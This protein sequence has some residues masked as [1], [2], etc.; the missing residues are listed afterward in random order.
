MSTD[1]ILTARLHRQE[2]QDRRHSEPTPACGRCGA[3]GEFHEPWHLCEACVDETYGK[4]DPAMFVRWLLRA[5][6]QD[7]DR[8]GLTDTP[9]RVVRALREQCTPEPFAFTVFDSEG[10]SEMVV[11]AGIPFYS[12]CEHHVLPFFG[13]AAVAYIPNGKVV[14]LSKLARAVRFCASGLQNQERI[15]TAVA[16]MLDRHL[17]PLGVG[18]VLRARH[19]CMESRGVRAPGAETTTSCLRGAFRDDGRARNE[20]LELARRSVKR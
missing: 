19:L 14:G 9:R 7:V 16:D 15:T 6:G 18:V 13:E 11:Q 10:M 1:D 3:A 4:G 8:E 5:L 20:F 17:A 2:E 12:L